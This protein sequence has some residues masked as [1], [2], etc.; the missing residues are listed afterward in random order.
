LPGDKLPSLDRFSRAT[1]AKR[2]A[3]G[4]KTERPNL[5]IVPRT[6]FGQTDTIEDLVTRLFGVFPTGPAEGAGFAGDAA[7]G[8]TAE[9]GDDEVELV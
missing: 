5:R 4:E 2:N 9:E 7:L 3:Q 8:M 6:E 1:H